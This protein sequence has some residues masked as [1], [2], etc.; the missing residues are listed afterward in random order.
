[1]QTAPLAPL[2][3]L[4]LVQLREELDHQ[5]A[6]GALVEVQQYQHKQLKQEQFNS[7]RLCPTA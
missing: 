4:E 6:A 3:L 5:A 2:D 7:E 1:M